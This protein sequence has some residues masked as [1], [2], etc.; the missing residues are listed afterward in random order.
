MIEHSGIGVTIKQL[1]NNLSATEL[2]QISLFTPPGWENH[3]KTGETIAAPYPIHGF[4]QHLLYP[5]LIRKH[6]VSLLH[7]PHYDVPFFYGKP[8]VATVH[9]IIH[10][11]YPEY[12]SKPFTR[13][14]SR[15][16]IGHTAKHAKKILTVSDNTKKDLEKYFPRSEGKIHVIY[17]A[18]DH[19][20]KPLPKDKYLPVLEKYS[21]NPGYYLYVG[22]LRASKNT[23][24]LIDAYAQLKKRHPYAPPLVLVGKTFLKNLGTVPEDV[25][26]IETNFRNFLFNRLN[27]SFVAG[28]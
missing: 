23:P 19:S 6:K 25:F 27:N 3:F 22:N 15:A 28:C 18:V 11:L 9:D 21:L 10:F 1:L 4:K 13:V 2:N 20:F 5:S 7:V 26:H 12:S 8:F 16:A 24:L 17:P 14:Y